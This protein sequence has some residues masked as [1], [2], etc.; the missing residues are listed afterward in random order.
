[1]TRIGF[2]GDYLKDFEGTSVFIQWKGTDVCLDFYC[3]CGASGHLDGDF[4]YGLRCAECGAE[5]AMPTNIELVKVADGH[6]GVVKDIPREYDDISYNVL[7]E[8]CSKPSVYC[9]SSLFVNF[10]HD[11]VGIVAHAACLPFVEKI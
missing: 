6:N 11:G 2:N 8:F 4:A 10:E 5:W 1:M 3:E 9:D 7:C